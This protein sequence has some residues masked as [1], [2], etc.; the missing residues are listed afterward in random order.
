[1]NDIIDSHAHLDDN[2]FSM[3]R[4][5]V[6]AR[7]EEYRI[8]MAINPGANYESSKKALRLAK[9]YPEK[10][11][12]AVGTHPHD[13]DE[14]NLLLLEEYEK[15]AKDPDVVAIGEIG[16]DYYY[17]NCDREVQKNAFRMQLDLAEK[18]NLP[19]IIHNRDSDGD[20]VEILSEYQGRLRGVIH[21]FTGSVEMAKRYT[22]LG[23]YL[24]F[25]GVVTFKNARK[26][27]E[28]AAWVPLERLLIE[29][30]APYLTPVPHR[31]KR[32]EPSYVRYTAEKIA[33]IKGIHVAQITGYSKRNAM[34]L[35]GL[36]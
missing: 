32:N 1:M 6:I 18:L 14:V 28:S 36:R 2:R 10:I 30:D 33:E 34:D 19:V 26:V 12:A 11:K 24:G 8:I 9:K 21:S 27:V 5:D 4:A 35:F 7:M 22:D 29:T 17:D 15:M 16:L 3:D 20:M 23:F 13:A 25:G 31:G